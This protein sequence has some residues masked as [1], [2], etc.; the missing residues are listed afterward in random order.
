MAIVIPR[1]GEAEKTA[2]LLLEL[3]DSQWD[4]K[5]TTEFG[6]DK[7]VAFVVPDDLHDRYLV[8]I[9]HGKEEEAE[10]APAP[11]RRGRPPRKAAAPVEEST[12][13]DND[14]T[15]EE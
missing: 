8:A 10:E 1:R 9:G 2:K 14:D 7:G 6:G 4:V 3:A 5:T 12:E 13:A 11:K 15:D